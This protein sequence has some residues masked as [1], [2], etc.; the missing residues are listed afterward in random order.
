MT[1][2]FKVLQD[3]RG[4]IKSSVLNGAHRCLPRFTVERHYLNSKTGSEWKPGLSCIVYLGSG[5]SPS[6][7]SRLS[8]N[9]T[10]SDRPLTCFLSGSDSAGAQPFPPSWMALTKDVTACKN[11]RERPERCARED[12][13]TFNVIVFWFSSDVTCEY[14]IANAERG[15]FLTR[16]REVL[17]LRAACFTSVNAWRSRVRL[18]TSRVSAKAMSLLAF[19]SKLRQEQKT[20][21]TA[22][23]IY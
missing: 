14:I 17:L 12:Y 16:K 4:K 2:S 10:K 3:H 9:W 21:L 18:G 6:I 1:K 11:T 8:R 23:F 22:S 7:S 5:I 13:S 19:T 15:C 20:L